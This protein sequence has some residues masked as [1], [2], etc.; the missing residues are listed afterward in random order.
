MSGIPDSFI[1]HAIQTTRQW[2]RE[3]SN[4][5]EVGDE[6]QAY[7]ILRAV[8]HALRARF[9]VDE[10]A[11]F[12]S[13]LPVF[14]RGVFFE[15]WHP[16]HTPQTDDS[17]GRFFRDVD[18]GLRTITLISSERATLLVYDLLCQKLSEKELAHVRSAL[19]S[20]L[21]RQRAPQTA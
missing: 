21:L 8:L 20:D 10:A 15:G 9:S 12:A 13:Q 7:S 4:D 16:S 18:S 17:A 3:I 14:W 6:D 5:R 11:E 1:E 19:P 2:L